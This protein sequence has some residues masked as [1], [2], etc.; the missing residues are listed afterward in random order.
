MYFLIMS[1]ADYIKSDETGALV[2]QCNIKNVL[3]LQNAI[4]TISMI[5]EN[6]TISYLC[7]LVTIWLMFFTLKVISQL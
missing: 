2:K 5:Q 1:P 3:I 4:Y 6:S 7:I